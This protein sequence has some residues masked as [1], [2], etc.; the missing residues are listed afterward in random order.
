MK[1]IIMVGLLLTVLVSLGGCCWPGHWHGGGHGPV[2]LGTLKEPPMIGLME[3]LKV[4]HFPCWTGY[5]IGRFLLFFRSLF[6][7]L[8]GSFLASDNF[9]HR[10]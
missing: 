1:K 2:S 9:C 5:I 7:Y 10:G 4:A 6:L 8:G 3:P